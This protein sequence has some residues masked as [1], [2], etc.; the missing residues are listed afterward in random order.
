MVLQGSNQV[1]SILQSRPPQYTRGHW[2]GPS[3]TFHS[4][5]THCMYTQEAEGKSGSGDT[6]LPAAFAVLLLLPGLLGKKVEGKCIDD[7][8][9]FSKL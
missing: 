3:R 9:T 5:S 7:N 1:P 6:Q 2:N 4:S 8:V